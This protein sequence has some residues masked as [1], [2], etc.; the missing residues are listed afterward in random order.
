MTKIF[1][2]G[3]NSINNE[4]Q[5]LLKNKAEFVNTLNYEADI[6]I[7]TENFPKQNKIENIKFIDEH[8]SRL[9]PVF[10]ST[11][12]IPVTELATHSKYPERI[13]GIG[14]YDTF[15][16]AKLIEIAP[17]KITD[18]KVLKNAESFFD[19][20]GLKYAIV[21]DKAGLVFP[22]TL[23][24]IIN[25]A[26][27]VYYEKIASREDID[28]A[29]K[30]GTN[31]PFGPLE[32]ADKIGIDLVYNVLIA[33]QNESGEEKYMPHPVLKEIANSGKKFY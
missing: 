4:L 19:S 30:L 12:C 7:D 6:I 28:T 2:L 5:S 14:L 9:V 22:R 13:I 10:T 23:A 27:E 33:M 8:N 1:V 29:M 17:T 25:E 16:G 18:K 21:P 3:K 31:Y 11:L 32:W 15:S 20:A 26:A 24:M